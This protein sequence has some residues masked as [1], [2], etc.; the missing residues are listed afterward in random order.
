MNKQQLWQLYS[1]LSPQDRQSVLDLIA[2]LQKSTKHPPATAQ[3]PEAAKEPLKPVDITLHNFQIML[4]PDIPFT[5]AEYKQLIDGILK[6][7]NRHGQEISMKRNFA[8]YRFYNKVWKEIPPVYR[9]K[10]PVYLL[11]R[12]PICA[13]PVYEAIDTF[14]LS[15]PG[16]WLS[17][18]RGFGW[19][20]DK[21][22]RSTGSGH[23]KHWYT[24]FVPGYQ[25]NCEHVQAV[26]YNVNLNGVFPNDVSPIDYVIIGSEQPQV[27]R[28]FMENPGSYAVIHALPVGR[29]N[30]ETWQPWY[31]AYFT[32]Y[33]HQE[34]S[35][36]QQ[37]L[38]GNPSDVERFYWPHHKLD[39]NLKPWLEK[40]QLFWLD[41]QTR[42][43]PLARYPQN[44]PYPDRPG[45]VGRWG[46]KSR[47]VLLLPNVHGYKLKKRR[48]L[49][50]LEVKEHQRKA[51]EARSLKSVSEIDR[52]QFE[53]SYFSWWQPENLTTV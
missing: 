49:P 36:F 32:T 7:I 31:T 47:E 44:F 39:F 35:A 16:W 33:F 10:L 48:G 43:L 50:F 42:G 27:L 3:K 14:T 29:R 6:L 4:E 20:Q 53:K 8:T 1:T 52:E 37:T 45:L 17:E 22:Q 38:G 28:P 51:L 34:A 26:T 46:L 24:Q 30:D 13:E 12:C 9:T 40:G 15:G 23:R 21:E 11:A 41:W 25:S 2:E 18:S 19:Y 5:F